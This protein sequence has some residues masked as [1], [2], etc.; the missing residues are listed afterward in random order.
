MKKGDA[1][2]GLKHFEGEE[3]VEAINLQP[4]EVLYWPRDHD[5]KGVVP[6]LHCFNTTNDEFIVRVYKVVKDVKLPRGKK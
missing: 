2:K 1:I 5:L 4:T 6:S 3:L